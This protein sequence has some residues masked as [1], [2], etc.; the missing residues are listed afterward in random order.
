LLGRKGRARLVPSMAPTWQKK[1]GEKIAAV[2]YCA[3][4]P[5][6]RRRKYQKK[7]P[8]GAD[9]VRK[10][11]GGFQNISINFERKG[12]RSKKGDPGKVSKLPVRS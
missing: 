9:C 1:K 12:F 2:C 8:V 10:K 5:S 7:G 11:G 3:Y 6:R 4:P